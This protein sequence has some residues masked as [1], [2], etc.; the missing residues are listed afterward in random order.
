LEW[1]GFPDDSSLA[2]SVAERWLR[3]MTSSS[4][5]S[6]A[7]ALAGGRITRQFFISSSRLFSK[8]S[9]LFERVHFF[10]GDERCVP[11]PHAD[12]NYRLA[13]EHLL[14]PLRIQED[15]V[16]RIRGELDAT[17]A[18]SE[19]AADLCRSV[20]LTANNQPILDLV[21]LGM[22]EDGHVASLFPGEPEAAAQSPAV[23][24]PVVATKPPPVRIT[25]GY[26]AIAAARQVWVLASGANKEEALRV[27]LSPDGK[28]PLARVIQMRER[29]VVFSD[30]RI[31]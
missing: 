29:T 16:H 18:A 6:F 28:T 26:D 2:E 10:W 21:F 7:V 24:R 5:S 4:A 8:K 25:L 17:Q 9:F 14:G 22:G 1:V 13:Y 23:Y 27:S 19:A 11:P 3:E 30:I 20:A 15:R 31:Q 12:S